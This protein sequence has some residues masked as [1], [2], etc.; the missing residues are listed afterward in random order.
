[1]ALLAMPVLLL[2][3]SLVT[4]LDNRQWRLWWFGRR[5]VF[6]IMTRWFF[7]RGRFVCTIFFLSYFSYCYDIYRRE[8]VRVRVVQLSYEATVNVDAA[9]AD[10]A[11]AQ[12][13]ERRT[14]H[15]WSANNLRWG[16]TADASGKSSCGL[17]YASTVEHRCRVLIKEKSRSWTDD[18]GVSH[19]VRSQLACRRRVLPSETKTTSRRY[20]INRPIACSRSPVDRPEQKMSPHQTTTEKRNMETKAF[21]GNLTNREFCIR[22]TILTNWSTTTV[23]RYM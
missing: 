12:V 10:G 14:E 15:G 9:Y 8:A 20:K 6:I 1:M 4:V 16:T 17:E 23:T 2:L 11:C 5:T 19:Y 13:G 3:S 18:Q 22:P 7:R 21:G